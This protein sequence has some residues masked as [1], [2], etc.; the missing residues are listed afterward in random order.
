LLLIDQGKYQ[1]QQ[2]KD[3]E[4]HLSKERDHAGVRPQSYS[5]PGVVDQGKVL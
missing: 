4:Q 3:A 5:I 1:Q 2:L